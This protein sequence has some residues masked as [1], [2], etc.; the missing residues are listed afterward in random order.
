MLFNFLC[1]L[2]YEPAQRI[3]MRFASSVCEFS[4]NSLRTAGEIVVKFEGGEFY[5]MS[6]NSSF[7]KTGQKK[8]ILCEILQF[9]AHVVHNSPNIYIKEKY[10]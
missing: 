7:V 6:T 2:Q 9:W 8:R 4:H 10:V 3:N 5:R 1:V